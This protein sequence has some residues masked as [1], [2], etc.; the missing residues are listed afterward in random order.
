MRLLKVSLLFALALPLGATTIT[1]FVSTGTDVTGDRDN[2]YKVVETPAGPI[3]YDTVSYDAYVTFNPPTPQFPVGVPGGWF[4][5]D[6]DS[7]W[8]AAQPDTNIQGDN[9]GHFMYETQFDLTGF[10]PISVQ[11]QFHVWADN[12]IPAIF[13]NSVA[14]GFQV[15]NVVNYVDPLS[16][17][18]V[19]LD[20][21]GGFAFNPTVN[22]LSFLVQNTSFYYPTNVS[23]FR[24]RVDKADGLAAV[25]EP[26]TMGLIG[27]GLALAGWAH[28][29]RRSA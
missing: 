8:I 27:I 23:G 1:T 5:D 29:R 9:L 17:T 25:P 20:D 2:K 7:E 6:V 3:T 22:T 10:D 13:L 14:T 12:Q 11:L 15:I 26:S 19:T 16:G 28:R 4:S 18:E 21:A 24:L